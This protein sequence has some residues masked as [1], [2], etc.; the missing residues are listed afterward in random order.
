[1]S[2]SEPKPKKSKRVTFRASPLIRQIS[3]ED[4]KEDNKENAQTRSERKAA[5]H[6][7]RAY[8]VNKRA[9]RKS[10]EKRDA[11]YSN[12]ILTPF[13]QEHP[14]IVVG[15]TK[16]PDRDD[17]ARFQKSITKYHKKLKEK[18]ENP[19]RSTQSAGRGRLGRQTRKCR[20]YK[21]RK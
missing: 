3:N 1:M 12:V 13:I 16:N 2:T 8:H 7:D 5:I 19:S 21:I 14:I 17:Y 18:G 15:K 4:A 20:S 6:E 11:K 9:D 10:A